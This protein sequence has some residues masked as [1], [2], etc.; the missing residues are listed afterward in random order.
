MPPLADC[1]LCARFSAHALC[2]CVQWQNPQLVEVTICRAFEGARILSSSHLQTWGHLQPYN[3]TKIRQ[4][5]WWINREICV[6]AFCEAH[7]SPVTMMTV[8]CMALA[9][10]SQLRQPWC[11]WWKRCPRCLSTLSSKCRQWCGWNQRVEAKERKARN[12]KKTFVFHLWFEVV[13]FNVI[14]LFA[15]P[16]MALAYG[17]SYIN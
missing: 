7:I 16:Q 4:K 14:V 6:D 1:V 8:G 15:L 11:H 5:S 2:V 12:D 17:G 13:Y 3:V 9:L 10:W